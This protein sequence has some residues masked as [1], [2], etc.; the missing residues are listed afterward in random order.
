VISKILGIGFVELLLLL[1]KLSVETMFS[2]MDILFRIALGLL[3]RFEVVG[4]NTLGYVL[5]GV[6]L[7]VIDLLERLVVLW[8]HNVVLGG[9]VEFLVGVGLVEDEF[10]LTGCGGFWISRLG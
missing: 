2:G 6:E 4:V 7:V 8:G 10:R 1:E 9:V 3:I 5:T